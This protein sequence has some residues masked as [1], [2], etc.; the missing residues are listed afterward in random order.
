MNIDAFRAHV[1]T[2]ETII[3]KCLLEPTLA[4]RERRLRD[5]WYEADAPV[6]QAMTFC[7]F[8]RVAE[9]RGKR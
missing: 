6:R 7:M 1:D 9:T 2:A 4:D 3:A 5:A 8:S